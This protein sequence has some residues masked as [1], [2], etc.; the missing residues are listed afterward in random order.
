METNPAVRI[1][2]SDEHDYWTFLTNHGAVLL[3]V[4]ENPDDTIVQIADVLGLRERAV[5]AIVSD[6]R[7]LGYVGIERRGRHNHY[8]VNQEMP[9]RRDAHGHLTV[10]SLL[11]GLRSEGESAGA[12]AARAESQRL[13]SFF[14][15]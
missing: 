2:F 11:S 1:P 10:Q 7:R 15:T 14:G 12:P 9:L 3:F 4:A 8:T 6:L 5:A 13:H